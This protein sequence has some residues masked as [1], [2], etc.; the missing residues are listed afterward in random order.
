MHVWPCTRCKA[1]SGGSGDTAATALEL[2][3]D[4]A[5]L[6]RADTVAEAVTHCEHHGDVIARTWLATATHGFD[7]L[8][9]RRRGMR[10]RRGD[11]D[12]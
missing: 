8:D 3:G 10:R 2:N 6:G 5:H 12:L 11:R 4:P 7:A 1:N 9:T